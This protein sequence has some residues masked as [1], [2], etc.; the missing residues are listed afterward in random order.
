MS[1][2]ATDADTPKSAAAKLFDIRLMIG[3]AL[4]PLRRDA[5]DRRIL[6]LQTEREEGGR[7]STSTCGWAS[8]CSSLGMLFLLWRAVNPIK[9]EPNPT[10]EGD[11]EG[12]RHVGH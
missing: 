1:G 7:A 2:R 6:H 9:V 12:G 8:G 11:A 5:D 4:R 10:Q 3:V